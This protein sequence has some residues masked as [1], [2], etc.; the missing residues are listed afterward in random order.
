MLILIFDTETTGLIPKMTIL[1][2]ELLHKYP[3]VV[4]LSY[5]V[6]DTELGKIMK[7]VDRIIRI[8]P[9]IN[10]S[11]DSVKFHGITREISTEK[12]VDIAPIIKDFFDDVSKSELLVAHNYAFDWVMI[13]VE[14]MRNDIEIPRIPIET[15]CTM[16]ETAAFCKIP[17]Q[18]KKPNDEYKWP[19]L[20]ELYVKLFNELPENLH[21]SL[22]DV[23]AT[24]RCLMKFRFGKDVGVIE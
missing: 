13:Q 24:L 17:S 9:K 5:I 1:Q 18:F 7:V 16:K 3:H 21:N 20:F 15:Y 11:K 23:Y 2:K 4:Q 12:G 8:D 19:T 10:I 14:C 6:Y 22:Y